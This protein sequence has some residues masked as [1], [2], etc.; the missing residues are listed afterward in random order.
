MPVRGQGL[1]RG[2]VVAGVGHLTFGYRPLHWLGLATGFETWVH[3][4]DDRITEDDFGTAIEARDFGRVFMF[5]LAT[6]RFFLPGS[7]RI[8]PFVDVGGGV[9][10]YRPPFRNDV[11]GVGSGTVALGM[12]AWLGPTF[13]LTVGAQYRLLAIRNDVG[14]LLQFGLGATV[15]W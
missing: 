15:H 5:D 2:E 4:A 7:R 6:V 10:M 3:D 8:E 1:A 9:G 12:E 14:H 13:S 11:L